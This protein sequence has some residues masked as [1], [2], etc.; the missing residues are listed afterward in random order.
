[1]LIA[2]TRP[3]ADTIAD[4][5]LTHLDREPI[6]AARAAEQHRKYR[7]LLTELGVEVVT[8]D[9]LPEH[10]DSVFVEDVS[11][12]L[13]EVSILCHMGAPTRRGET[14]ALEPIIAAYR[15]THRMTAP[16]TMEGGDVIKAGRTL[17][18]GRSSRTNEAGREQLREF[19]EPLGYRVVPVDVTGCLHLGT[20]ASYLGDDTILANPAWVDA[21]AFD[22]CEVL[23]VGEGEEWAAN[24]ML[25]NGV[26]VCAEPASRTA[27]M[28][29]ERGRE[30][31]TL[32]ISEFRKA[33]GSLT[34][35]RQLFHRVPEP[36]IIRQSPDTDSAA[37]SA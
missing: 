23:P 5:Q 2:I 17:F 28:L 11:V 31:R 35:M 19:T 30:V 1:M 27:A 13:D 6:D 24:A 4:C 18:V 37:S 26:I 32:D 10:P 15:Q 3:P 12:T 20:G 25:V 14:H 36:M 7:E 9:P 22:G 21:D 33:E 16:A 8:L 34:C 29:R